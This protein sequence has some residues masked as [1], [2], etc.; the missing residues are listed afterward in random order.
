MG[1]LKI[2]EIVHEMKIM[3]EIL[4]QLNVRLSEPKF[5]LFADCSLKFNEDINCLFSRLRS[6][7][8]EKK[9]LIRIFF[10]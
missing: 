1:E 8:E 3:I 4:C 2:C 10:C 7:D 6:S 5:R 9:I